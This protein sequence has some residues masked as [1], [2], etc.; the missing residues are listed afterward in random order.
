MR[1]PERK[2][3]ARNVERRGRLKRVVIANRL[4][5]TDREEQN[6]DDEEVRSLDQEAEKNDYAWDLSPALLA[7]CT[8]ASRF[9]RVF[10]VCGPWRGA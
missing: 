2:R 3:E 5:G 6:R 10:T 9:P 1:E 4:P 8:M 7:V